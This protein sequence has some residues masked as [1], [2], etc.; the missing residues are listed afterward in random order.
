MNERGQQRIEVNVRAG[1]DVEI[2]VVVDAPYCDFIELRNQVVSAVQEATT[3][4]LKLKEEND[5]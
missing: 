3:T 2:T 5:A 4:A 1:E